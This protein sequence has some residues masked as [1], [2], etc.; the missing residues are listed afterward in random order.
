MFQYYLGECQP[1]RVKSCC[2]ALHIYA[3]K[4]DFLGMFLQRN[5]Y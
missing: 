2:R 1:Q 4:E 5:G 3:S